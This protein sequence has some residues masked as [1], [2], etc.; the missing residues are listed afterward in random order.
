MSVRRSS[1]RY[2]SI[3]S[4]VSCGRPLKLPVNFAGIKERSVCGFHVRHILW[5]AVGFLSRGVT[6]GGSEPW[7]WSE[8]KFCIMR[9]GGR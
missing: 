5:L 8:R 6:A 3:S 4:T 9:P 1:A 2:S 7:M